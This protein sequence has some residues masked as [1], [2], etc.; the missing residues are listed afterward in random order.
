M[1]PPISRAFLVLNAA[2]GIVLEDFRMVLREDRGLAGDAGTCVTQSRGGTKVLYQF[3]RPERRSSRR[4]VQ[5]DPAK[6]ARRC[7]RLGPDVE[8]FSNWKHAMEVLGFACT[9]A[10]KAT[11]TSL[12]RMIEGDSSG[13]VLEHPSF[14]EITAA[15]GSAQG[16]R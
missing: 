1:K 9:G 8:P 2:G 4:S 6:P 10:G 13:G 15:V 3:H 14:P 7:L 11:G 12:R 16:P 5:A